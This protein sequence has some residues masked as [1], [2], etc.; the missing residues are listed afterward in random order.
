MTIPP[1]VL[2][3]VVVA[4]L[5]ASAALALFVWA[6]RNGHF[7]PAAANAARWPD[8]EDRENPGGSL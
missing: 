1:Q 6:V 8:P 5:G 7:D 2:F 3:L 4:V